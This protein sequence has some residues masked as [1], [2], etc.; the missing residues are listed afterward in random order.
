[1]VIEGSKLTFAAA[2]AKA[3]HANKVDLEIIH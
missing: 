2:S 1:L 3:R